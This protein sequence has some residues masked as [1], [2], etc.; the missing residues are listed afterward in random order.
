MGFTDFQEDSFEPYY[1]VT[2]DY[3]PKTGVSSKFEMCTPNEQNLPE[4]KALP[5]VPSLIDLSEG[6]EGATLISFIADLGH[7][8]HTYSDN[9]DK[10][11]VTLLSV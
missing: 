11:N 2:H 10:G 8:S 9:G 6:S 4:R 7:T 1:Y 3:R 5:F